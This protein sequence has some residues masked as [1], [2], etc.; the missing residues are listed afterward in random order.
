MRVAIAG[1]GME[2]QSSYRYYRRLGHDV[3]IA[4]ERNHIDDLPADAE[5]VLGDGAFSK[6]TDFD[7]V[8]RTP[9][10][11]PKKIQTNGK[12]WSATNEFFA[13]CPA[14][15]I[16]VTGT[17]GKGT[18]CSFIT[19]ILRAAGH[20]V[21]LVGNIGSPALD[22]LPEIKPDD[23]VVYELSSFQ[24]W[25]FVG[26]PRVA[27][28]LMIEPDHLNVHTNLNDYIQAK[29]NL[30]ANMKPGSKV[31]YYP[32][33]ELSRRAVMESAIT[34]VPFAINQAGSVG[35]E[36]GYLVKDGDI[37]APVEAVRL[38]GAH[39]VENA[40]AAI[41]VA[42][43]FTSDY[44]AIEQGVR[45]FTGLDHRLKYIDTISGVKFYDDSIA[46]T[47]GSAMAALKSFTEN[48]IIILGGSDK[49]A[50]YSELIDLCDETSST[51]IAIGESQT[52][53]A[54]LCE[55]K[56][57]PCA[58]VDG[59]MRKIVRDAMMWASRGDVVIL[60]P[61]AAS[62]DMFESY[63]DRGEQFIEAVKYWSGK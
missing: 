31:F 22:T 61:A 1:Y 12:I 38:P 27:V 8:I 52:K 10:L 35:V 40:C 51:V 34:A 5:S 63:K 53:I 32:Y 57:V 17:K 41:S 15:I 39:N 56:S 2:G 13:Q 3:V 55:L 33:S 28:M 44:A 26:N 43:E 50:D 59:D 16:G 48:K 30:V 47:P 24:L 45:D 36:N 4:D 21:H 23:I 46:T 25:D 9:G 7:Q 18:T 29:S 19:S 58:E 11:D 49:G 60:S 37:I 6:L 62:F 20:T 54:R 14:P 42:L